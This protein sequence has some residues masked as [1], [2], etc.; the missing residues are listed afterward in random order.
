M[1]A[2]IALLVYFATSKPERFTQTGRV[3]LDENGISLTG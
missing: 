2:G 3:F 1:I